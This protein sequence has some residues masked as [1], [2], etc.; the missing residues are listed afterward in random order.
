MM[1]VLWG[2]LH[3][4][5]QGRSSK[6]GDSFYR[7]FRTARTQKILAGSGFLPHETKIR[8]E[9]DNTSQKNLL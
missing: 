3:M 7:P 2:D 6:S 4:T 5:H 9:K 8:L 1:D